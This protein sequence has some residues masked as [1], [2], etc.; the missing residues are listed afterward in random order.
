MKDSPCF[1]LRSLELPRCARALVEVAFNLIEQR[2]ERRKFGARCTVCD[3]FCSPLF[4][5][6]GNVFKNCNVIPAVGCRRA[7]FG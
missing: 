3:L 4:L 1:I 6:G 5:V 2:L 7:E